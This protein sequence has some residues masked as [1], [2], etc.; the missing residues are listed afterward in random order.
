VERTHDDDVENASSHKEQA[1]DDT[2][3]GTGAE[4]PAD[5]VRRVKDAASNVMDASKDAASRAAGKGADQA[6]SSIDAVASSLH[7]VAADVEGE[8]AWVGSALHKSAQSLERAAESLTGGDLNRAFESVNGF[9]RRQPAI[10]LGVSI[11]LGFALAR[12]GKTA[13]ENATD[14]QNDRA[15]NPYAGPSFSGGYTPG[16]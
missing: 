14:G 9:A 2:T 16:L 1:M 15:G 4:T 12:V 11:A 7:R 3:G 10:F 8:N 13:I 5:A 6:R